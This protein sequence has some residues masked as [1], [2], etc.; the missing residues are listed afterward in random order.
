MHKGRI[1]YFYEQIA[2]VFI[3]IY[4]LLDEE[5]TSKRVCCCLHIYVVSLIVFGKQTTFI[6]RQ[7]RLDVGSAKYCIYFC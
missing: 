5:N 7:Q 6:R 1:K 2:F 4:E 3:K